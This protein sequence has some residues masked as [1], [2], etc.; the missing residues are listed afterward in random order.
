MDILFSLL[1]WGIAVIAFIAMIFI[2]VFFFAL[3][4]QIFKAPINNK[5][6][7]GIEVFDNDEPDG[8]NYYEVKGQVRLE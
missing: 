7:Q 5:E 3:I 6:Y 2:V 1:V 4:F 8:S